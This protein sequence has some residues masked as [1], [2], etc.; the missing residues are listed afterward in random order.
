MNKQILIVKGS[1]RINGN[2]SNW[3]RGIG[4]SLLSWIV[5]KFM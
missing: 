5:M 3:K 4:R 2:L 1:P